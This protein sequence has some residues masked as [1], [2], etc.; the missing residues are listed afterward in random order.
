MKRPI[1][2]AAILRRHNQGDDP[3]METPVTIKILSTFNAQTGW[4]EQVPL[5]AL[6]NGEVAICGFSPQ[7]IYTASDLRAIVE[8]MD[9]A[10]PQVV[11]GNTF[12][13]FWYDRYHGQERADRSVTSFR[14]VFLHDQ[15][16]VR[17][18]LVTVAWPVAG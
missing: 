14:A 10:T 5:L 3:S 17:R 6:S 13:S 15:C 12:T 2:V 1:V 8:Q 11:D 18:S 7:A 9:D 4:N 16:N